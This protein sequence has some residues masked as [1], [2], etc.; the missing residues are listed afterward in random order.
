MR[1]AATLDVRVSL[2]RSATLPSHP[3]GGDRKA[4]PVPPKL[5]MLQQMPE[6]GQSTHRQRT[7]Q[8]PK[9]VSP[10]LFL[11]S[12]IPTVWARDDIN[13]LQSTGYSFSV[14]FS[15]RP[16][17]GSIRRCEGLRQDAPQYADSRDVRIATGDLKE[18][19]VRISLVRRASTRGARKR[20]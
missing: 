5:I 4:D 6:S 11:F 2:V 17:R 18:V 13:F 1:P 9:N 8:T 20:L 19:P 7:H 14:T 10:L 3:G 16:A 15:F 12:P